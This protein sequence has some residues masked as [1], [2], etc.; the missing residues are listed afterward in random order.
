[1]YGVLLAIILP[2]V[3]AGCDRAPSESSQNTKSEWSR[4]ESAEGKFSVL[5]PGHPKE[6]IINQPGIDK[7]TVVS[8]QFLVVQ[9]NS[10]FGVSYCDFPDDL[11]SINLIGSPSYFDT[12]QSELP[13]TLGGGTI[14]DAKDSKFESKPMRDIRFENS[15]K[16][17]L[18]DLRIIIVGHRQ[19]QLTV[20]RKP[21]ADASKDIK[22]FL[23]SFKFTE[24][25]KK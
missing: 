3:I 16:T 14:L 13:K 18:R 5:L 9:G 24:S 22:T 4:F 10:G 1:M 15:D 2:T 6:N 8:H 25:V 11:P 19:Y 23:S 17:L 20:V 21:E 7:T 12:V